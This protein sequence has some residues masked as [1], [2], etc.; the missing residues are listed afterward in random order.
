MSI[1]T[2]ISIEVKK[3]LRFDDIVREC[4]CCEYTLEKIIEN[5]VTDEFM[6]LLSEVFL[7]EIPSMTQLNDFIRFEDN[8]IFESLGIEAE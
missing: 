8:F 3:E 6:V 2:I 4:W 5:D 7:E 1:D